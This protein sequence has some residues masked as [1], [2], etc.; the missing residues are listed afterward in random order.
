MIGGNIR[1]HG[2]RTVVAWSF[3]TDQTWFSAFTRECKLQEINTDY[4]RCI[5]IRQI[6]THF[7]GICSFV[8]RTQSPSASDYLRICALL[9]PT[10]IVYGRRR[11]NLV[12]YPY[13]ISQTRGAVYPTCVSQIAVLDDGVVVNDRSH[14]PPLRKSCERSS[15]ACPLS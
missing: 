10:L 2:A 5:C 3:E 13:Q 4:E 1:E 7:Y 9:P 14:C 15:S 6:K 8:F 12:P 11:L